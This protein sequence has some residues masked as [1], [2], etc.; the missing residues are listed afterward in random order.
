L[1][2]PHNTH[3]ARSTIKNIRSKETFGTSTT[4]GGVEPKNQPALQ[5]KKGTQSIVC[6][7]DAGLETGFHL[8]QAVGPQKGHTRKWG[9][10]SVPLHNLRKQEKKGIL[11]QTKKRR[12]TKT[13]TPWGKYSQ[14]L[15]HGLK[16]KKRIF[17][18]G[19]FKKQPSPSGKPTSKVSKLGRPANQAN[20]VGGGGK[21]ELKKKTGPMSDQFSECFFFAEI[22]GGKNENYKKLVGTTPPPNRGRT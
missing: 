22:G 5:P 1:Y 13:S 9:K 10:K 20:P 3:Q 19:C 6:H 21:N 16:K 12:K 17:S 14:S 7:P 15:S 4:A 2:L 18:G 8:I 11:R